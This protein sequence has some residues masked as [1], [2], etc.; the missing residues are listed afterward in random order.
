MGQPLLP[1]LPNWAWH[2]YGMRVG[3]WRFF[4]V[5]AT[6]G[7]RATF[8]LNGTVCELYPAI[9]QAAHEAGWDFMGHGWVQQPMHKVDDQR[10]AIRAT[11]RRHRRSSPA[12]RP[13][14]GK[15]PA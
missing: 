6:R 13:A 4:D 9:C 5:L 12:S 3:I 8:A 10:A 11:I 1:D 7:L 14:G 2:E 15:A